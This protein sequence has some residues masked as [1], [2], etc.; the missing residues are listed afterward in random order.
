MQI[1]PRKYV[2]GFVKI[3]SFLEILPDVYVKGQFR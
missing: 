3:A 2:Y 1:P